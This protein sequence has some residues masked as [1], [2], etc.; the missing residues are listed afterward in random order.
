MIQ[1]VLFLPEFFPRQV[2]QILC[3]INVFIV[4]TVRHNRVAVRTQHVQLVD[5]R[6]C[7][8]LHQKRVIMC[9]KPFFHSFQASNE[10]TVFARKRG[11][12]E[13][14]I[15]ASRTN[16]QDLIFFSPLDVVRV[17]PSQQCHKGSIGLF[18]PLFMKV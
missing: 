12:P 14:L 1:V 17:L 13:L 6:L 3:Q 5:Y 16:I 11:Q 15:A 4:I 10:F 9:R 7:N 8:P 18:V 2:N